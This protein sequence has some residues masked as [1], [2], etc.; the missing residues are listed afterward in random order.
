MA[1]K[2]IPT[3]KCSSSSSTTVVISQY[4]MKNLST[5]SPKSSIILPSNLHSCKWVSQILSKFYL[6]KCFSSNSSNGFPLNAV[7][8]HNDHGRPIPAKNIEALVNHQS[9]PVI[10]EG[11]M[12]SITVVGASGDLAKK[13]I[14]PALFALFYE[15]CLP[16]NFTIFGYARTKMSDEQLR[17]MISETLTCRIDQ[18]ENCGD[19]MDQFLQRC[20]YHSGLYN[21]EDDFAELDRK[22]KEK[23]V[24]K[25]PNRLFYLSIPPNIFVDVVRCASH[26]ASSDGGWTRVIV[27]KPFGRDAESSREL[28]K[29][30][31]QYLSEDQIFRIDHYLGKE[32]V[33]NLSVLRFSNL[34]FEPLWSRNY[35]RNVQLIFSEDFGTEGRGGYFDR[36]GI[37]RDIMQ[38]HLLQILALFAMET[39]VSLD[40]EDIRNEK[41]KL[42]R[43]MRQLKLQD[44]VVGQY[45]G[46]SKGAKTYPGYTD[47]P[48]VPTNSLTPTFA[49]LSLFIDNARWDGVPFLMK[50]GKALNTRRAEI[51]VQFRHVP[52]NL[53]KK[54]F[55]TGLDNATNE[56][57]IRVQPDEAIFLKVNNKVPGLGM[58]LDRSDLNLLYSD[59]YPREIPDAYERLLLDAIEGERRLFIRSDELDA[60]WGLFTPLLKE[61]EDRKIAPELYPYG[62]RGPVGAHYLAAKHNV[63]WG[64][65]SGEY[66]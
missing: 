19:K 46:H 29:S 30:L 65:V 28:T 44:V 22:L 64:D 15:G 37:I 21:S 57:V 11:S 8:L 45:K 18:R 60:A 27:E 35:I 48:T 3:C 61:L 55:G 58:R 53:Y 36:Y 17:N 62:S 33:E 1:I 5:F 16:E 50:A 43:S 38:N 12:L 39:P 32:L 66:S 41:V 25:L 47:D 14:F 31:K 49:A 20:F 23:E 40:A 24:G 10:R 4:N 9:L 63:R 54:T 6:V 59:R 13:K 52:G 2:M 42:L 56:L 34:V 51:R 26:R 7:S